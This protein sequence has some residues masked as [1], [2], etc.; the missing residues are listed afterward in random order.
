M[1]KV[2][3][4][5]PDIVNVCVDSRESNVC[6]GRLYCCYEKGPVFFE[7]E[8]QIIKF[9]ENLMDRID[10]P[11]AAVQ[12]RSYDDNASQKKEKPQKIAEVQQF[13]KERGKTATFIIYVKYRQN[14]TWQ[15]EAV[16]VERNKKYKFLSVLELLKLIDSHV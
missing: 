14:A 11:Q 15:G 13:I 16:Q 4:A 3:I 1:E 9:M 5:A 8:Y 7:N 12:I 2:N 6:K 10:H